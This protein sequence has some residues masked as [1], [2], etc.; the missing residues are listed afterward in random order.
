LSRFI[1]AH[2]PFEPIIDDLSALTSIKAAPP[3]ADGSWDLGTIESKFH[4]EYHSLED[5]YSFA[6]ALVGGFDGVNGLRVESF[7]VGQTYEGRDIRGWR[8]WVE[9]D[10]PG[11]PALKT[12]GRKGR[13]GG[14][15]G[16][17]REKDDAEDV[18]REFVVQ[19]GQHAREVSDCLD[20]RVWS[21]SLRPSMPEYEAWT[22]TRAR[23]LA[24]YLFP[25]VSFLTLFDV[26]ESLT[27]SGSARPVR[28][29]G[30]T[31]SF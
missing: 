19:A 3:R 4:D 26:R 14:K 27:H 10:E 8:A 17:G 25:L 24:A 7:T 29:T 21:G 15:G 6:D 9:G 12:Q 11:E 22:I 23:P 28:S 18:E 16:R 2:T 31:T 1:P 20:R 13:K 5:I 30:S